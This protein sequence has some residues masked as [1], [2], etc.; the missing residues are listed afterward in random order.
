MF[1][2]DEGDDEIAGFVDREVQSSDVCVDGAPHDGTGN[3]CANPGLV[4]PVATTATSTRRRASPTLDA[5][6]TSLVDADLDEDYAGDARSARRA[7]S[8]WAPTS[9]SRLR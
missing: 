1:G 7:R 6:D 5:G 9:T 3:I 8:T 4:G 2:N